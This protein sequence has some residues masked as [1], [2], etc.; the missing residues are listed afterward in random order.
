MKLHSLLRHIK[1]ELAACLRTS[2][3]FK[4]ARN[5]LQC[6]CMHMAVVKQSVAVYP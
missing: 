2:K 1:F 6:S 4:I 3:K 5:E